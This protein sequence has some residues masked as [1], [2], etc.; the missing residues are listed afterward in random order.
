MEYAVRS[1]TTPILTTI[2]PSVRVTG[3]TNVRTTMAF[4]VVPVPSVCLPIVSTVSAAT[5]SAWDRAKPVPQPKK[6][7]GPTVLAAR[8]LVDPIR[9][10]NA[11]LVNAMEAALAP[12]SLKAS[13]PMV[14]HVRRQ[15]NATPD[16]ART[17]YVAIAGV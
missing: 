5:T 10:A 15:P 4:L 12:R 2:A 1:H 6:A 13:R 14:R 16:S 3:R 9:T 11:I 17:A 8:S 7:A